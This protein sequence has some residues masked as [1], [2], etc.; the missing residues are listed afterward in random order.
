M[1]VAYLNGEFLPL[2]EAKISP[3]DRGFLFGDGVYEV[4]PCYGGQAVA[5][6][7]HMERLRHSLEGIKLAAITS[8]S[9]LVAVIEKLIELNGGGN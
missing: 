3:M 1:S 2:H 5:M 6:P 9:E 4:I 8:N 7:Y